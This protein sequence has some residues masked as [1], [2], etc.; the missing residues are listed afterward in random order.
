MN[1]WNLKSLDHY[2]THFL[3]TSVDEAKSFEFDVN[4]K[5]KFLIMLSVKN[6]KN[7]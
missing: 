6:E 2:G 4:L 5:W 3:D 1:I 7:I